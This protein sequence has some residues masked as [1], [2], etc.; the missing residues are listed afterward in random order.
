MRKL[1]HWLGRLNRMKGFRER[2]RI[3]VEILEAIV[4]SEEDVEGE[5]RSRWEKTKVELL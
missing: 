2:Q 5:R 1:L 3:V 4:S